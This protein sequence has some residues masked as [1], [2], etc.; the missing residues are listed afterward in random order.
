MI[1]KSTGAGEAEAPAEMDPAYL[2]ALACMQQGQWDEAAEALAKID[3]QYANA[4]CVRALRQRLALHLSAEETWANDEGSRLPPLLRSRVV[5]ALLV[6]NLVV[7]LLLAIGWLVGI[8]S[9]LL[10]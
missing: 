4:P 3:E 5:R 6:A 1:A 7:Y 8:W 9:G 2:H 10:G